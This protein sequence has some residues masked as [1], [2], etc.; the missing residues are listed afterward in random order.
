MNDALYKGPCLTPLLFDVLARFRQ[1]PIGIIAD[2]EKTYLQISV[3]DCHRDFLRFLWF[4]DVFKDIPEEV[5][6]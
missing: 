4:D 2:I 6:F 5:T 1:N 3:A